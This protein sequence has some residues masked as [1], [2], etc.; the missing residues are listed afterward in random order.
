MLEVKIEERTK[1]EDVTNS[2]DADFDTGFDFDDAPQKKVKI[3]KTR[4]KK[5]K[6]NPER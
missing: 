5:I 3:K 6:K 1:Q 2:A 4:K